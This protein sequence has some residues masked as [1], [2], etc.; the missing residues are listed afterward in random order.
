MAEVHCQ[1]SVTAD[2]SLR[3]SVVS[4]IRHSRADPGVS[5]AQPVL[6]ALQS[7]VDT[8]RRPLGRGRRLRTADAALRRLL[9]HLWPTH[10]GGR[11]SERTQSHQSSVP[12]PPPPPRGKPRVTLHRNHPT[13]SISIRSIRI[14]SARLCHD[15]SDLSGRQRTGA[16]HTYRSP[17]PAVSVPEASL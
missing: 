17:T 7:T 12:P 4:Y 14:R 3:L 16:A 9:N 13:R 15:R 2:W 1:P 5:P 6:K 10:A 8:A 11:L